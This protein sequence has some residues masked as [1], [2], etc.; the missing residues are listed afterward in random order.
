MA[1]AS[2]DRDAL[3]LLECGEVEVEGRMP[4]SSN[5]TFLGHDHRRCPDLPGGL[6]AGTGRAAPVGL[7]ARALPPRGG[8]LP[9]VGVARLGPRAA[10]RHPGRPA[11]R[12]VVPALHRGRLRAALL[13]A[14]RGA[15]RSAPQLRACA[16]STSLANNTDRKS[17]H[18]LLGPGRPDLGQSTRACASPPT[19]S[20]APSS[21][22]SAAS[23]CPAALLPRHRAAG[24]R[25]SRS[26]SPRCSTTTRSKRSSTGPASW[27]ANPTFP[28]DTT[29]R[30]YPWPVV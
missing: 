12:G 21:G 29:G 22:S 18:V 30:R 11:R 7:P 5:A 17:G 15:A 4:W 28:V 10:H 8:R 27:C 1:G 19:S 25:P 23:P 24:R 26:T 2:P 13:H 6:Q 14:L 3:S 16:R 9:A 20:C